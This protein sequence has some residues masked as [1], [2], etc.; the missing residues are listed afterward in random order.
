MAKSL[1]APRVAK[2]APL[3]R[4]PSPPDLAPIVESVSILRVASL[5]REMRLLYGLIQQQQKQIDTV[6]DFTFFQRVMF[7][8]RGRL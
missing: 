6:L 1:A 5:E 8:L 7:L 4:R 2:R 3:R